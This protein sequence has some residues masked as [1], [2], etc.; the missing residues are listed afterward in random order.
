M[1]VS[2]IR[3]SHYRNY[4]DADIHFGKGINIIYG[5]NAQGKTNI[6]ESIYLFATGRSHRTNKDKELIRFGENYANV[7]MVCVNRERLNTG[8]I[9]FAQDQKKRI[10]IN[11]IPINK[12]GQLM[13][14]FNVVMFSPEDLN[15]IKEGPSQRRRFLDI[16][17]SQLRP[18]YFYNLQQY[19]KILEQRNKLLKEIAYLKEAAVKSSLMDTLS[20]WDEKLVDCG[21]RIILHRRLFVEKLREY[22]RNVHHNITEGKEQLEIKYSPGLKMTDI[23]HLDQLKDTFGEQLLHSRKR[24]LDSGM[25]LLGPHRDDLEFIIND[26]QVKNYASQGQQRTVVLSL[27]MAEMEFMKEDLGEY[28]VL[29]LDDIMSELDKNRQNYIMQRIEDKQVMITC[30]DIDRFVIDDHVSLFRI[31]NGKV[32]EG[33]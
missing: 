19:I 27:K 33:D 6:L 28:P 32:M 11:D 10:K 17:I 30:T 13:G 3:L 22:A 29:L 14:F 21:A 4:R 31:E 5:N 26:V 9:M 18:G 23:T 15:L 16:C 8:E 2:N 20:V 1:Y 24:E 12:I 25:T 7:K